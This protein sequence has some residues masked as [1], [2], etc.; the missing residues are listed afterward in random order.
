V[1]PK[2]KGLLRKK[3]TKGVILE[4]KGTRIA[5]VVED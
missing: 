1:K 2:N 3:N 5:E 4:Q